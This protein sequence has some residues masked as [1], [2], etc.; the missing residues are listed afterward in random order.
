LVSKLEAARQAV[1][2]LKK[3]ADSGEDISKD[4]I[5][6]L[7]TALISQQNA[8]LLKAVKGLGDKFDKGLSKAEDEDSPED[9]KE[10]KKEFPPED[11][12]ESKSEDSVL[13]DLAL[14]EI[15]RLRKEAVAPDE[16]PEDEDDEDEDEEKAEAVTAPKAGGE[17]GAGE[18]GPTGKLKPTDS[19]DYTDSK[20]DEQKAQLLNAGKKFGKISKIS[21]E[22]DASSEDNVQ[23]SE[24]FK[25][26]VRKEAANI[27]KSAGYVASSVPITPV[28][29]GNRGGQIEMEGTDL[30]KAYD[31]FMHM[32][33]K[34][35]NRFRMQ[36]DPSLANLSPYFTG[37][38]R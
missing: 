13:L 37:G 23:K 25:A 18:T 36:V 15:V 17:P 3:A 10:D 8:E 22:E 34:T 6:A 27:L 11:V 14:E 24:D 28:A 16:K 30:Q 31:K 35:I 38:N 4:E 32:D 33:W 1:S 19:T 26:A 12:D 7:D 9:K 20:E 5:T 2:E 21:K 29:G